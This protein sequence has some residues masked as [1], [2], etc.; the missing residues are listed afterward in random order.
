MSNDEAE[1]GDGDDTG[2]DVDVEDDGNTLI[3]P[4]E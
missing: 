1:V 3:S 2:G 4:R